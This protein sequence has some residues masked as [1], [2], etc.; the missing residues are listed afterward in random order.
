[1]QKILNLEGE[2]VKAVS[3]ALIPRLYRFHFGKD[4]IMELQRFRDAYAKDPL[5][6]DFTPLENLTWLMLKQGGENVGE[7]PEEWLATL[8]S[9]LSVYELSAEIMD[10]W[11]QSQK[12]TSTPKK[13]LKKQ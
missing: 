7:Q 5:S 1:M 6:V 13:K 9:P 10:L 2:E 12:V 8:E 4:V 11:M 3:N